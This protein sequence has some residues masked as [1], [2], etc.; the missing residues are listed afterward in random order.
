MKTEYGNSPMYKETP[1]LSVATF[2]NAQRIFLS[3]EKL[4]VSRILTMSK[5]LT[6]VRT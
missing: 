2:A 6:V 1:S 4:S 5:K 3:D